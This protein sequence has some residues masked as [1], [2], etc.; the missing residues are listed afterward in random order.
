MFKY[1]NEASS[2]IIC[3]I[4][5]T[6]PEQKSEHWIKLGSKFL[7]HFVHILDAQVFTQ[8]ILDISFYHSKN[9][10]TLS[11]VQKNQFSPCF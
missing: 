7:F 10:K 2:T 3:V 4:L 11:T 5:H 1:A 8:G 9:H 6:F